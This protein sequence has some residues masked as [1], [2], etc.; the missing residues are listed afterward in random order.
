MKYTREKPKGWKV[1]ESPLFTRLL[2]DAQRLEGL[3][4]QHLIEQANA[5]H[6]EPRARMNAAQQILTGLLSGDLEA[7]KGKV[8]L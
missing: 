7:D 5:L 8:T 2:A 4:Y 3:G 1:Q 6:D